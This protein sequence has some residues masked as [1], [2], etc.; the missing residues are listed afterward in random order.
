M[1]MELFSPSVHAPSYSR[2]DDPPFQLLPFHFVE[3]TGANKSKLGLPTHHKWASGTGSIGGKS[4]SAW[5]E[6]HFSGYY[7]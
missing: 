5:D 3:T 4:D 7:N 6:Y 2:G 1:K